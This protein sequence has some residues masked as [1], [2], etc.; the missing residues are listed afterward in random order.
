MH[1]A[2]AA[3]HARCGTRGAGGERALSRRAFTGFADF[4]SHFPALSGA[5]PRCC[6]RA[7]LV[8]S[9]RVI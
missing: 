6:P 2:G 8:A 3:G 7:F 4:P 1:P 5:F 9:P